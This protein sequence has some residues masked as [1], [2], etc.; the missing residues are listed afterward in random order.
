M[1]STISKWAALSFCA[2]LFLSACTAVTPLSSTEESVKIHVECQDA[3]SV[4]NMVVS[5]LRRAKARDLVQQAEIH[6]MVI[7]AAYYKVDNSMEQLQEIVDLLTTS[8]GVVRAEILENH[9]LVK[10]GR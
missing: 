7:E 3:P 9:N 1:K 5:M 10:Q 4:R 6:Y 8:S 2:A